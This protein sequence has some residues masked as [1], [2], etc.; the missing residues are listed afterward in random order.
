MKK[1]FKVVAIAWCI[2]FI[3]GNIC[4]YSVGNF[5]FSFALLRESVFSRDNVI[6]FFT[7][8]KADSSGFSG[9]VNENQT[10]IEQQG[11]E[12]YITSEDN[13]SLH[14]YFAKNSTA[15]NRYVIVCH[16]YTSMAS[17]MSYFAKQFYDMNYSV[18]CVDARAHGESEG[19]VRGMGYLE[20]RDIILWINEITKQNPN[21]QIVLYGLSMGAATVLFTSGESDLP[22]CVKAVISD[23]AYTRVYEEIGNAVRGFVW[24]LPN[25][26]LVDSASVVCEIRGGYSFR[27]A[28][29]LESV[30]RSSTPTLFI[31]GSADGFVPF[32][33]LDELYNSASCAKEKLVIEGAGHAQSATTNPELYWSTIK[34]FINKNVM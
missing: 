15:Q 29:C 8:T 24:F 28:S 12:I 31:H 27:D 10:W 32:Y 34:D 18:L 16:G 33:M 6:A 14:G 7:G 5:I 19:N 3:L 11:E 4:F 20:R 1:F 25:F 21:A 17:H 30:K 2:L 22:S 9:G 23:C 13:L 26:P